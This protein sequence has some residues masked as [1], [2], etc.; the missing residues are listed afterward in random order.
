MNPVSGTSSSQSLQ[1][2]P[3]S[4]NRLSGTAPA[5]DAAGNMSE[6]NQGHLYNYDAENRIATAGGETYIYD[7]DGNRVM[8]TGGVAARI[9]WLGAA[10]EV[11]NEFDTSGNNPERNVYLAGALRARVDANGTVNYVLGDQI[12]S[13]R[14]VAN[15]SGGVEDDIDYYPFG[16]TTNYAV[17]SS[18]NIY[19]FTGKERDS[20]SGLDYFGARYYGSNMGRMMSPDPSGLVYADPTNPQ[21]LNLYSYVL[22][23]PLKFTDPSGLECVWDDGS[24]DSADDKQ[25]GSHVACSSQGGTYVDPTAF[26]TYNAGDWSDKPNSQIA[27]DA[28]QL[29]STTTSVNVTADNQHPPDGSQFNLDMT[30]N[31][32]VDMMKQA[33]FHVSPA[34]MRL[35]N[36]P[37]VQMRNSADKCNVHVTNIS[38]GS[39]GKPVTGEFHY[40]A[41]NPFTGN[42]VKD[43]GTVTAH[44]LVDYGPD[45]IQEHVWKGMPTGSSTLCHG[46]LLGQ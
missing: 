39:N 14:I 42:V 3:T 17:S 30:M 35:G 24:F 45:L 2:T 13:T 38:G 23:S 18:S 11:L 43:V 41:V 9:Y 10:S 4:N 31:Q 36:H 16:M 33:G 5:Y 44:G 29:N 6:D 19:K 20:E 7:G 25:T 27:T 28:Q 37:G 22:N 32:F 15:A 46:G 40:D 26:S 1:L 34:D 21:S 12:G 8:K